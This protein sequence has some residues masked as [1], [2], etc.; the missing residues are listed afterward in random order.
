[1]K[2]RFIGTVA[3]AL[4]VASPAVGEEKK[5]TMQDLN[6]LAKSESWRELVAHFEDI[7]PAQRNKVWEA[8]VVKGMKGLLRSLNEEKNAF[9][10]LMVADGST[11]RYPFLRKEKEFMS[12]R[13]ST[14]LKG[15]ETCYQESYSGGGCSER[16]LPFVEADTGNVELATKAGQVV[17]RNQNHYFAIPYFDLAVTWAKGDPKVC[18]A[19]RLS[20]ALNAALAVPKSMTKLVAAA[21][22]TAKLCWPTLQ[23]DLLKT[24][25]DGNRSVVDSLCPVIKEVKAS[26]PKCK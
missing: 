1:M 16:F 23:K 17:I 8:I 15:F 4:L 7:P 13:A 18:K 2:A 10:M 20:E 26:A 21:R 11:R 5:Y 24:L 9:G 25:A 3:L 19:S 6:A 14:G 22:N 12:L